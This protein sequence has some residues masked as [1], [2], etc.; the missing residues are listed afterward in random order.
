MTINWLEGHEHLFTPPC[1]IRMKSEKQSVH[2]CT[3][4]LFTT[5]FSQVVQPVGQVMQAP[6]KTVNPL[7]QS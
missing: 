6:F 2:V 4:A 3:A 1:S 5:M 7:M